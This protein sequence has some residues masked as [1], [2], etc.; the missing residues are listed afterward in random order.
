MVLDIKKNWL[1]VFL[2]LNIC[3]K[4][5]ISVIS[6]KPMTSVLNYYFFELYEEKWCRLLERLILWGYTKTRTSTFPLTKKDSIVCITK[7]CRA[8]FC[9]TTASETLPFKRVCQK[10]FCMAYFYIFFVWLL[11][12]LHISSLHVT[13]FNVFYLKDL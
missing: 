2:T 12:V 3:R 7:L 6:S 11:Q 1:I 10:C 9:R 4:L 13:S 8:G 5:R